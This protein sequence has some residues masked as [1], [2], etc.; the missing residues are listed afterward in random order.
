LKNQIII[1]P[2]HLKHMV[3]S[4]NNKES[5]ISLAFNLD[6]INEDG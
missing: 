5:R 2:S 4:N 3:L 1:F 6:L